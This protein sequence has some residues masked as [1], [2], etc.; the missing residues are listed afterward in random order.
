[1]NLPSGIE[2]PVEQIA[3]LC[4]R[5]HIREMAI[6][7]SAARGKLH[8]APDVDIFLEFESAEDHP[9]L[10]W[11]DM[12]EELEA[13]LGRRVDVSQKSLLKPRVRR[14]ALRDAVVV[15]A[16]AVTSTGWTILSPRPR[17]SKS[18]APHIPKQRET[19]KSDWAA[20]SDRS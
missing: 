6:F 5:Y 9:G 18:S 19:T 14:E 4:G 8:P 17:G 1:M 20:R 3:G 16:S 7:G 2:I 10:R 12:E 15:Y 13:I 11:F